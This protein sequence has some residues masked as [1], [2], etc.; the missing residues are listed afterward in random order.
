MESGKIRCQKLMMEPRLW[1]YVAQQDICEFYLGPSE[2]NPF[3]GIP[4]LP[5]LNVVEMLAGA[6][7]IY[8]KK[9]IIY[10]NKAFTFMPLHQ[11]ITYVNIDIY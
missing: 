5:S 7:L 1:N 3:T 11:C 2:S 6:A 10:H 9:I 8:K 4:C